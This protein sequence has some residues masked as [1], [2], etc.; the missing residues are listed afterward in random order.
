MSSPKMMAQQESEI[1]TRTKTA[2]NNPN[3]SGGSPDVYLKKFSN[4]SK[5]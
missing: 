2:Q 1:F 3:V 5:D 4:M